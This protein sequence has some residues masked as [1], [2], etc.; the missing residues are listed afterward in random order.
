M[1][2]KIYINANVI[3]SFIKSILL[4]AKAIKSSL[5]LK[6][7]EENYKTTILS[8]NLLLCRSAIPI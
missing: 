6:E 3:M 1:H 2:D 8:Q 4:T 5:S 7:S